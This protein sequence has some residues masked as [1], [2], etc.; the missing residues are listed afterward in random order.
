MPY[1]DKGGLTGRLFSWPFHADVTGLTQ[2][3]ARPA[4]KQ[5]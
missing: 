4:I 1:E 3:I 2:I 5:A